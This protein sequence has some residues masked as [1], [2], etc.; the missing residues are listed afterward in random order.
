VPVVWSLHRDRRPGSRWMGRRCCQTA[1]VHRH[2]PY[3]GSVR[4]VSGLLACG[5]GHRL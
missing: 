3:P 5:S 4:P 2:Q 1:R